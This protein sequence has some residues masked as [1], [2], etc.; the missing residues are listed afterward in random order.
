MRGSESPIFNVIYDC[1][2]LNFICTFPDE[3]KNDVIW[4]LQK[5]L[6]KHNKLAR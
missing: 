2:T 5:F 1:R 4:I 3:I 6:S